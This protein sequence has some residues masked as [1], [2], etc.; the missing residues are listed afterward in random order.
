MSFYINPFCLLETGYIWFWNPPSP[1]IIGKPQFSWVFNRYISVLLKEDLLTL[2]LLLTVRLK[3]SQVYRYFTANWSYATTAKIALKTLLKTSGL[4][5]KKTFEKGSQFDF[6]LNLL[7][8]L[9]YHEPLDSS[10]TKN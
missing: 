3:A 9:T 1:E 7:S 8:V 2:D 4:I 5:K 6:P 10:H